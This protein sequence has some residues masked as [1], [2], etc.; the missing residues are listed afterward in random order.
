MNT[1]ICTAGAALLLSFAPCA[2]AVNYPTELRIVVNVSEI[3]LPELLLGFHNNE[4]DPVNFAVEV[5][6][7]GRG[8]GPAGVNDSLYCI[9]SSTNP[10]DCKGFPRARNGPWTAEKGWRAVVL[11]P[12]DKVKFDTEYCFRVQAVDGH[13]RRSAWAPW[14][15]ARTPPLPK[16]PSVAPKMPQVSLLDAGSTGRGQVGAATQPRML[17]EWTQN[18]RFQGWYAI[19]RSP[20][21]PGATW[22][23]IGR[24]QSP[25]SMVS[26]NLE[27]V[28]V[29]KEAANVPG[30]NNRT[31]YRVCAGNIGG[32]TCSTS[33]SYPPAYLE[34]SVENTPAVGRTPPRAVTQSIPLEGKHSANSA[35]GRGSAATMAVAPAARA[36][37]ASAY[38]TTPSQATRES[39]ANGGNASLNPQ[40]LPPRAAEAIGAQR[41]AASSAQ[42][43]RPAPAAPQDRANAYGGALAT[44]ASS[45]M[46]RTAT[47]AKAP[48]GVG[49]YAKAAPGTTLARP[50]PAAVDTSA[51]VAAAGGFLPNYGIGPIIGG[52]AGS[53]EARVSIVPDQPSANAL[54]MVRAE[55]ISR[56]CEGAGLQF[57]DGTPEMFVPLAASQSSVSPPQ[58]FERS[59]SYAQAGTYT[60]AARGLSGN[61]KCSSRPVTLTVVVR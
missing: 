23:E 10:N 33:G 26:S 61:N 50:A 55:G 31:N 13:A 16:R 39:N 52:D 49:Q 3:A 60:I 5:T 36:D 58:Q 53:G 15:C 45:S 37:L 22:Q 18:A 30:P 40:P 27:L 29:I 20:A 48:G 56:Y 17:I 7:D 46:N 51:S 2:L 34:Q 59:H 14:A 47:A 19:E 6:I 54:V 21:A 1:R 32:K 12:P 28:E 24:V 41:A 43:V 44:A 11:A 35:I 57:G 8:L 38:R 25:D 4:G 9:R 42:A